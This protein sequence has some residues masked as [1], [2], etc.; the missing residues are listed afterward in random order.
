ME[1]SG[2]GDECRRTANSTRSF[3]VTKCSAWLVSNESP[4]LSGSIHCY[5]ES[6]TVVHPILLS[7]SP[8]K[9]AHKNP[10]VTKHSVPNIIGSLNKRAGMSSGVCNG[11]PVSHHEL[12]D[13]TIQS[14]INMDVIG[15]TYGYCIVDTP[16]ILKDGLNTC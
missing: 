5:T 10:R 11:R 2:C 6:A 1:L 7:P 14:A 16:N 3:A 4:R 15:G 8:Y 9:P 13:T 12:L